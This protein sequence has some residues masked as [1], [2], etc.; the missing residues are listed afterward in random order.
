[1][2]MRLPLSV[3]LLKDNVSVGASPFVLLSLAHMYRTTTHDAD[4]IEVR[5]LGGGYWRIL[6]G[7]HRF[8]ASVVAGRHD[9]LAE[10]EDTPR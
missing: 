4:P 1:M 5:D 2:T 3:L 9:I 8:I 10:V 7:R 6:D